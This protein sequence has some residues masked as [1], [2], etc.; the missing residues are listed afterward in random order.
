MKI[1]SLV[2][3]ILKLGLTGLVFLLMYMGYRLLHQEQLKEKPDQELLKKASLFVWQ[4]IAVA[5]LVAATE[6]AGQISNRYFIEKPEAC[7]KEISALNLV[8][9]HPSQSIDTLRSAIR[10]TWL[11]CGK[12]G[13]S[14]D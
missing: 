6:L 13:G 2:V 9:Q 5:C 8:S 10:N 7:M 12:P 3:D 4:S 1:T 11:V 14:N